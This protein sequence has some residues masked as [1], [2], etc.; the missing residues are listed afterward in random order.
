VL[1]ARDPRVTLEGTELGVGQCGGEAVDRAVDV[2]RGD[3]LA[4][5]DACRGAR[6][7]GDDV[8][9]C[10]DVGV[11]RVDLDERAG[12]GRR[13]H[14]GQGQGQRRSADQGRERSSHR[15]PFIE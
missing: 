10:D 8:L 14:Q 15:D 7:D 1:D 5:R 9:T 13:R 12:L 2:L 6:L 11:R 3:A 4:C